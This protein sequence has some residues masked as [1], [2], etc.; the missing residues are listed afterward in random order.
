MA[1]PSRT[2]QVSIWLDVLRAG[3]ATLCLGVFAFSFHLLNHALYR[4][5]L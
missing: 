2:T 5:G 1:E 4:I 3:G